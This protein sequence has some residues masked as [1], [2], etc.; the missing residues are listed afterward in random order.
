MQYS[1]SFETME[2]LKTLINTDAEPE[3]IAAAIDG[4][5][6]VNNSNQSFFNILLAVFAAWVGAVVAFYFGS[7]NLHQAQQTL[8]NVL[9]A[10]Q[11]GRK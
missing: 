4:F 1:V 11:E 6:D 10:K 5:D 3:K 8:Q 2:T 9:S 7:E